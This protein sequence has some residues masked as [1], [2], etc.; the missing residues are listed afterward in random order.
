MQNNSEKAKENQV[1]DRTFKKIP[2]DDLWR[3]RA[4]FRGDSI[5]LE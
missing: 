1:E 5:L 2:K 3:F 4:G